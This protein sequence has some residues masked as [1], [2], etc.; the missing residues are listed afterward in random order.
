MRVLVIGGGISDERAI[1]LR[2]AKSV[3]DA[4]Q[5]LHQ[6]EFYDW[7]G[8]E[9]WL[10]GNARNYDVALPILHGVGGEDGRIQEILE[11]AGLSYL[12]SNLATSKICIDKEKTQ[13]LLAEKGIV[14]P[15][16]AVVALQDYAVHPLAQ[17][18]H[19]LKPKL[20]GSS[21]DTYVLK[22]GLL[23][24]AKQEE[25][26]SK[27][28]TMILEECIIGP[29]MTVPVLEGYD[30]PAIEIIP[31]NEFFDFETKYD[32]SSKEICNSDNIP[33]EVQKHV[34]E[35]AR[36][37]HEVVGCRHLSR[38]DIML[39]SEN[40]PY[41]IEINTMPGLTDQSLFP[42]AAA[43]IGLPMAEL[44]EHFINLVAEG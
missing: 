44:V 10:L 12:G 18:P 25:V 8:S 22:S 15:K 40:K 35:V 34:R 14:V 4:I 23:E 7:D 16:Q 38:V 39:D 30:L 19:V 31:G 36:Q 11:K 32:G 5:D 2:S 6:K 3:F 9:D 17:G 29:E 26:F 1:S 43:Y 37:A 42:K 13:Q 21:I 20:G 41:V 27:H 33:Q 24:P 28:K